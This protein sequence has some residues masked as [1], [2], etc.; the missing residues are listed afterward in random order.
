LCFSL[1]KACWDLKG[2]PLICWPRPLG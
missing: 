1:R 2:L